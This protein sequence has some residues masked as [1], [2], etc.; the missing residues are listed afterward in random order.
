MRH[1]LFLLGMTMLFLSG[2]KLTAA[3]V[4]YILC[5]AGEGDLYLYQTA[6]NFDSWTNLKCGQKVEIVDA[7]KSPSVRVRTFDGK[8]GYVQQSELSGSPPLSAPSAGSKAARQRPPAPAASG[9]PSVG[10]DGDPRQEGYGSSEERDY[11]RVDIFGAYSRG[12]S[13]PATV[14][15]T[16]TDSILPPPSIC[17]VGLG[18]RATLTTISDLSLQP[19]PHWKC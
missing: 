11:S 7:Q 14:C 13:L 2:T 9:L 8:E 10:F 15:Q 3:D 4:R 12:S 1:K 19:T 17:A 5:P 16:K 6:D 18:W